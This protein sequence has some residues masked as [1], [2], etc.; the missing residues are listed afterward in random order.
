MVCYLGN[1]DTRKVYR[2]FDLQNLNTNAL[3]YT[4][5]LYERYL[6][7]N[8][9]IPPGDRTYWAHMKNDWLP[10]P[11]SNDA[12]KG[13]CNLFPIALDTEELNKTSS[14]NLGIGQTLRHAVR[15]GTA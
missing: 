11:V 6:Q 10:Q 15:Q 3:D 7:N 1:N 8:H 4:H 9:F 5:L 14:M 12:G 13:L 2:N